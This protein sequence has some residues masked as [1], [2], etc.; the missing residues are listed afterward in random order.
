MLAPVVEIFCDI[1]DFCKEFYRRQAPRLLPN[2]ERRRERECR[3][4]ISEIMTILVLFQLSHNRT[5]KDFYDGCVLREL[6]QYFPKFI[7]YNR[8]VEVQSSM[9]PLLA[10]YMLSK[11]GQETG[12]YYV[13]TTTL[14][15]CHNRRIHRHKVFDGLAERGKTSMGWFFGFKLHLAV[16][17]K[18]EIM[19]FILTPGNV[20]DR[21]TV[22]QLFK[23]LKGTAAADRGYIG[24]KLAAD[25][26]QMG[27]NFL[28]KARRNMKPKPFTAFE[29]MIL[30]GR[31]IIE[32]IFDQLKALC[33]IEHTRHRKP[34]NFLAN[35]LAALIDYTLRPRKPAIT[36]N[37]LPNLAQQLIP[38]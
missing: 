18:G 26:K 32:T 8:F 25:L 16:N 27:I 9:V 29:S 4:T 19:S 3:L 33:Q 21:K 34:D 20:D 37:F 24:K 5:F 17:H 30:A 7:S 35:L 36:Q 31:S 1:D 15:V 22:R 13:D 38:N 11:A 28:T 14:K 23:G 6:R 12:M 10:V 2:P